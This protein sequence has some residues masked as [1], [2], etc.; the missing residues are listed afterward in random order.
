MDFMSASL[1]ILGLGSFFY[2][3]SLRQGFQFVDDLSMLVLAWSMLQATLTFRQTA[4][5]TFIINLSLAV[6]VPLFSL[7][8]VQTRNVVYHTS[9]FLL[10]IAV[11]VARTLY[12][13]HRLQPP[14]PAAKSKDWGARTWKS[15]IVSVVGYI[16]WNIDL[17]FC[18]E[19]RNF[20][21]QIGLPWAWLFELHG[22]WHILTAIG[23]STFMDVIREMME[24]PNRKTHAK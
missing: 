3:A 23:A 24:T 7:Y 20:R 5:T 13:F 8:Y 18:Q 14:L 12:L 4:Q 9:A 11:L 16:L 6:V 21:E 2:H 17:E 10:M 15:I 19:L 1:L 22:W